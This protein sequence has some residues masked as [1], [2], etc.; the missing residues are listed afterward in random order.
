[1]LLG[2]AT[3]MPSLP[4]DW[5]TIIVLIP[6]IFPS[7]SSSGP[8]YD[9]SG[10]RVVADI[11]GGHGVLLDS[12][13]RSNPSMTGILF[14]SEQVI[15][16]AALIAA[17]GVGNRR[18]NIGGDFFESVPEGADIYILKNVLHDWSDDRAVRIL[19]NCRRVMGSQEKLLVIEMVLPLR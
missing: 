9:F 13:M 5:E 19:K 16:G 8:S 3:P 10:S 11:G 17:N 14:D 2:M 15:E 1:M 6:A 12:I 18:Q 4:P 7:I